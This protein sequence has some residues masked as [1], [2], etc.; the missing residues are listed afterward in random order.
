ML[1]LARAKNYRTGV[2]GVQARL[3][4]SGPT[5]FDHDGVPVR[6]VRCESALAV[7]EALLD[8]DPEGWLVVLTDRDEA[9]LGHGLLGRLVWQRLRRP[10]PW[11]AVRQRFGASGI[12]PALTAGRQHRE[13]AAGLLAAAPP[14]G[15][16]PAP[17][18]VL[19]RDHALGAAAR[20]HLGLSADGLEVDAA[21]VLHWTTDP[22]AAT[23]TADLRALAGDRLADALLDWVSGRAGASAPPL[24][25]LLAAGAV[26]EAVPLGLVAGLLVR[27]RRGDGGSAADTE[28]ARD[29]LIRLESRLGPA[30]RDLAALPAWGGE[31][32]AVAVDLLAAPATRAAGSRLLARADRL[33]RELAAEP[34]AAGSDLLPAGLSRR[35]GALATALHTAASHA[36]DLAGAG[37][38]DGPLLAGPD[39][40][41]V[42]DA[43]ATVETH[44]LA[45][46]DP[47]MPA[48]RAAVRL[49]RW[50][51]VGTGAAKPGLATL[52]ERHRD[53]DAFVDS[54]VNDAAA[55]VGEPDLGASMS[56]VLA[57]VRRRRDAHDRAFGEALAGHT[58][59]DPATEP[60]PSGRRY[61]GVA[62]LEDLLPDLVLPLTRQAPVLLLVMDG[63]SVS[64]AAEVM[65]D[66]LTDHTGGWLEAVWPGERGRTAAL[67]VLPTLT[68][69]SRASLLCG[70][71]RTGQQS[72]ETRGYA[73]L[74]RAHGAPK[75]PPLFHKGGLAASQPGYAL[76]A[77]VA[78][79]IDDWS[80]QPLVSCVLN[81]I[82]DALDRSDPGG[83]DWGR[84]AIRH[85]RPLLDRARGVG[86][87]VVLTADH[88]HVIERRAGTQRPY[89][90]IS[91]GRSRP[92]DGPP[93]GEGEVLVEGRRV[94][95]HDNRAVLAVD[96]R[97]RYGP[98]KA[99]YHGG[100]SPAEAVVPV[101]VLVPGAVP[102]G[103][104]LQVA[105]PQEPDWWHA[106]AGVG[107]LPA[108]APEPAAAAAAAPAVGQQRARKRA[109]EPVP[110]PTL[111]DI[112]P[113][114]ALA[115]ASPPAAA[116]KPAA[117]A[118]VT[119]EVADAVLRSHAYRQ[120]R[121][122]ADR[123]AV[124]D[125]QL[126]DLLVALLGVPGRRLPPALAAAA[127]QV[128]PAALRGALAHVLR[129]LNV[130]GYPV[131][132]LD[133]DGSTV[134]LD[135]PLLR[136][137]FGVQP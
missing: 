107:W 126:R 119:G 33:L 28:T 80:G 97:L 4:W 35:L 24:R 58:R 77:D 123:V 40:A 104:A 21:A 52:I 72:V 135:E 87:V 31:A 71:L 44:R 29:A 62:H 36:G 108:A 82:D 89:P 92:G 22:Q 23:R 67:A 125:A 19:T 94:L 1:D 120:Q 129:L 20:T 74:L 131:L 38:V 34:L 75:P 112:A 27:A 37:G 102:E 12:D 83:T 42:E 26:G 106:P 41:A 16:P 79:A 132:A 103:V 25:R 14:G 66:I 61:R 90:G 124:G 69:V 73:E 85:L 13:L 130:E 57:V 54:A 115:P 118:A 65:A 101:C 49:A 18:G 30:A 53:A 60:G 91:S 111:F 95:R 93:P 88:G 50:L 7:R 98:L 134:V 2:L 109:A 15:W 128:H 113:E 76:A 59:D 6:V 137:Q 32:E 96:E 5:E 47:R 127:L 64:V 9:D 51:A 17:G 48:L 100:A 136:E 68:D 117:A 43:W 86:R 133:P 84:E 116:G 81:A 70:E 110:A 46:S 114:G 8:R 99:G 45:T 11:D 56:A 39:L 3:E 121:R 105:G 78:A 122:L 55:G 10:D 63:M